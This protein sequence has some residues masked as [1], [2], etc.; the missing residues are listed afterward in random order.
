[1][2][3]KRDDLDR[4]MEYSLYL[5]ERTI[6]LGSI[7]DDMEGGESG[8]DYKMAELLIKSLLVL[9]ST[10]GEIT[11]IMNNPGGHEIHG[12]AIYDTI[13]H[14]KNKITMKV[15]GMAMSMGSII[16]QSADVRTM[17]PHSEL[18]IH[19]GDS[20]MSTHTKVFQTWADRGKKFD[21]MMENL[22][23]EKI[24]Q[25]LPDFT[26]KQLKNKI[27]HDWILTAE[28]ALRYGLIDVIEGAL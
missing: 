13:K 28:E 4:F 10:A 25:K 23:L 16:L 11:I 18:L 17:T 19:Y 1:M 21:Q 7:S 24:K 20:S 2:T 14:C 26:L 3:R 8:T 9:D 22:F 15:C 27:A 12:M 6:Y 5:P